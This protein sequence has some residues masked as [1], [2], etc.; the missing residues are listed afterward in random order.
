MLSYGTNTYPPS[1][2]TV[3]QTRDGGSISSGTRKLIYITMSYRTCFVIHS[4]F[5]EANKWCHL[6]MICFATE[7]INRVRVLLYNQNYNNVGLWGAS[8]WCD[9]WI[10]FIVLGNIKRILSEKR[11]TERRHVNVAANQLNRHL[12]TSY[13]IWVFQII[14]SR[15]H[16]VIK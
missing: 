12:Y 2:N 13:F 5:P 1:K 7:W 4:K 6:K 14:M 15:K 9:C 10:G 11:H 16:S 3:C 8:T